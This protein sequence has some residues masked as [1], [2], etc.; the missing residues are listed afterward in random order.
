MSAI[1]VTSNYWC[2]AVQRVAAS[3]LGSCSVAAPDRRADEWAAPPGEAQER[4]SRPVLLLRSCCSQ[5]GEAKQLKPVSKKTL[6]A[7]TEG[8][9]NSCVVSDVKHPQGCERAL[10]ALALHQQPAPM[11]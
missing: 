7:Q 3:L 6:S 11:L 2:L 9:G 1:P 4:F 5:H 10:A 8:L